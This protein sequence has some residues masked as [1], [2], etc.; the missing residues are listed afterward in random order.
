MRNVDI[1]HTDTLTIQSHTKRG[2]MGY[3]YTLFYYLTSYNDK[4]KRKASLAVEVCRAI[5]NYFI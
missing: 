5:S 2:R 4:S 3:F 1:I